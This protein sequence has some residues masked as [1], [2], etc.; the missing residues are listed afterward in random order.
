ME[1]S[2]SSEIEKRHMGIMMLFAFLFGV[3]AQFLWRKK[4]FS[5]ASL[6][7]AV[8]IVCILLGVIGALR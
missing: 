4:R 2:A 5:L 3:A 1:R 6:M 7:I 8:T